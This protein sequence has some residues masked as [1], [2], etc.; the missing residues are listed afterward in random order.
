MPVNEGQ[1]NRTGIRLLL[2]STTEN[3]EVPNA[4]GPIAFLHFVD[5]DD[6]TIVPEYVPQGLTTPA[7]PLSGAKFTLVSTAQL[8]ALE[9]SLTATINALTARVAALEAVLVIDGSNTRLKNPQGDVVVI[10]GQFSGNPTLKFYE[11]AAPVERQTVAA[12]SGTLALDIANALQAEGLLVV[13]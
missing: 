5:G 6:N 10:A 4:G 11:D 8:T 1:I 12:A 3:L 7:G 13:S 2:I 9:A